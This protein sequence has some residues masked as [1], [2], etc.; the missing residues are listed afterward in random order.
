MDKIFFS[1]WYSIIRIIIIT[2]I[3]YP[4]LIL[5][6]RI[7]GKRTLSKMNA[8]DLIITIAIGS[9]FA[10]VI[11][12][13]DVSLSEGI[14]AFAMLVFFQYLITYFSSRNKKISKLVKSSPTL[15]AYKGQLLKTNML[16][17]RIDEDEIWA[18][19]RKKG[20]SALEETVAIVLETDGS[21]S[22]IDHI[23]DVEAPPIKTL[24]DS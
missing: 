24:L 7:S 6:L 4:A 23:K 5:I 11:L 1:N 8:F 21:L 22:V 17:E 3:A 19:I 18:I 20:Y 16:D 14:L 10:T 15:M 13:K 9:I 12:S 2:I